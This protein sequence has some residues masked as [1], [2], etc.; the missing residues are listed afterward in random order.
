ML[1]LQ[2]WI[3][4]YIRLICSKGGGNTHVCNMREAMSAWISE[5]T[6]S[7]KRFLDENE[8]HNLWLR[9]ETLLTFHYVRNSPATLR[10][11]PGLSYWAAYSLDSL[12]SASSCAVSFCPPSWRERRLHISRSRHPLPGGMAAVSANTLWCCKNQT[13]HG[14]CTLVA[15]ATWWTVEK[16]VIPQCYKPLHCRRALQHLDWRRP[17]MYCTM[18]TVLS[19]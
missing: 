17:C 18:Y 6:H 10:E 8:I 12:L 4:V 19:I 9:K 11:T 15:T 16:E 5:I 3:Y 14:T 1:H 7:I 13:F 2:S